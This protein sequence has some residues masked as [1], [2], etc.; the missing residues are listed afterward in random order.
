VTSRPS[1][2]TPESTSSIC[3]SA[4]S[5][6]GSGA[7]FIGTGTTEIFSSS[8]TFLTG[9]SFLRSMMPQTTNMKTIV[10]RIKPANFG[11]PF[12]PATHCP[13][14]RRIRMNVS[15]LATT[16]KIN[17][18]IKEMRNFSCAFLPSHPQPQS[19]NKPIFIVP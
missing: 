6:S 2:S 14:R 5:G 18:D 19:L 8:S 15:G 9:A 13:K 12:G 16:K 1:N 17:A 10:W 11:Q 3:S 4:I 7:S